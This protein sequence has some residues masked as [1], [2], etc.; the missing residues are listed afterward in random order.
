M[1]DTYD[2]AAYVDYVYKAET[3]VSGTSRGREGMHVT[4][5]YCHGPAHWRVDVG[6]QAMLTTRDAD[7]AVRYFAQQATESGGGY[8]VIPQCDT[9]APVNPL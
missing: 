6:G 5:T 8:T 3:H 7:R 9:E 1:K 4:L 2:V